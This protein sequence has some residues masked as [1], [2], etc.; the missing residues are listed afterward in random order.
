MRTILITVLLLSSSC[1]GQYINNHHHHGQQLHPAHFNSAPIARFNNTTAKQSR[2]RRIADYRARP[3]EVKVAVLPKGLLSQG[4]PTLPPLDTEIRN[5]KSKDGKHTIR[6]WLI[7]TNGAEL[8]RSRTRPYSIVYLEKESNHKIIKVAKKDLCELDQEYIKGL[9][10][11]WL[12]A[13]KTKRG[14]R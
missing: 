1:Y 10:R 5:W 6:A 13:I 9:L 12:E 14:T 4:L 3:K 11:G 2:A 7:K 8:I